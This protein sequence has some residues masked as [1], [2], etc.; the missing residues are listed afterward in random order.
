MS[1]WYIAFGYQVVCDSIC[2][3]G[4]LA[5][6]ANRYYI[7]LSES[8]SMQ[9]IKA[10]FDIGNGYIKG[11]VFANDDGKPVILVKDMVKTKGMRKG[12]ILDADTFAGTLQ[13]MITN[14]VKKLGGDF[15]DEVYVGLSHPEFTTTRIVESKRIMSD[16]ITAEDTEHLSRVVLDV[17]NQNNF[18]TIKIIPVYRT[19]DD[20]KR[21]K[22]PVGLQGKRLEM[23]AD[24]FAL[25]KTFYNNLIDIFDRINLNV[26]DIVPNILGAAE[27]CMDF[28]HKD[29]GTLLIDIGANQTSFVVYEE[30]YPI[31]YDTI[32]LGGE[33][34]TKDI[35]IGMQ[36]D[37]AERIKKEEGQ[38]L[39]EGSYKAL[40]ED[41]V[42]RNF[43]SDI[44][45]ARYEEIFVKINKRLK[46]QQKDGR[47]P[48]GVLLMGG[49]TKMHNVD[50]LAKDVF[51]LASFY[52][53][54]HE[55]HLG[56]VSTNPQ[57]INTLGTYVRANK[58]TEGRKSSFS[59]AF[60]MDAFKNIGSFFKKLF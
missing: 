22:D 8:H 38:I 58:Y 49:A 41:P 46:K 25:P 30:G 57:F 18:E 23:T 31:I 14:F 20:T 47:L 43:L 29:L 3:C 53:K 27:V 16:S 33:D 15:I 13:E 28:D 56:D 48:G 10:I 52:A 19:I 21:E 60:K 36:I 50:A 6:T 59:F 39:E 34:V 12:K 26:V 44:I 1:L 40:P 55:L 17:S 35:S 2:V 51:K 9:D 5:Y 32:A 37:E 11:V 42:D 7:L 24:V 54:D 4:L 45:G